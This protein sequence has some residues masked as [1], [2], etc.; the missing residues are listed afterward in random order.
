MTCTIRQVDAAEARA[1]W[2]QQDDARIFLHPDVLEPLC[3]RVDWWM[4]DWNTH[5]VCLWPV[6]QAFD[7]SFRP[8]E[9]SAYVGPLWA[10]ALSGQKVHRWWT[11]AS[12]VQ[13]EMLRRLAREYGHFGFELPPGTADVRVLQWFGSEDPA[14]NRLALEC[15]HTATIQAQPAD[16]IIAGFSRNRQRDLRS[17]AAASYVEVPD[18]DPMAMYGLYE[19]MLRG[20]QE[21]EKAQ[22]RRREVM[23]LFEGARRGFGQVIA[24]CD[25]SRA[26]AAF[27]V[28]LGIRRTALQ[29]LIVSSDEARTQGLQA[30]VQLQAI[31]RSFERGAE[32]FDF[33]GGNSPV[34]AEEKH[35]YGGRPQLYFRVAVDVRPPTGMKTQESP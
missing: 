30:L 33:V 2:L 34:G 31:T 29:L 10:D 9:L 7:G 22:R 13:D 14:H 8:P 32:T 1:F 15:R 27:T 5:P 23:A 4:A 3:A 18:A 26:P 16:E 25:G 11:Q 28:V 17:V 12:Q 24:Y 19:E 20:K 35:R 21:A 6:C